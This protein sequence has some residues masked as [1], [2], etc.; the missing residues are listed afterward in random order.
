MRN[1]GRKALLGSVIVLFAVLA[2]LFIYVD[3][4][5]SSIVPVLMYHSIDPG[6]EGSSID[7]SPE[8]FAKQMEFL[9]RNHYNVVSPDKV[10]AYMKKEEKMPPKTA[11]IT[12]DDGYYN[13]YE[14]AYPVLKKYKLPA[15]IF[16]TTDRIGT[17]GYLG[18][19]ELREISASGLVTI[20]SHTKSHVWVPEISVNDERLH[21]ELAVSKD[22]LERALGKK[23]YYLCYPNGGFNDLAK[24]AAKEAGY[25]GAF[26]TNP[27]R[28]SDISDIYAIRRL[29]MSSSS[30]SP[31]ILW[32]KVSR[33]YAWFKERR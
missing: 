18:W 30:D 33:Y 2:G 14:Y 1:S 23:V 16:V 10:I 20:G 7:V 15:A 29:K 21:E 3:I 22:I 32:G 26:T 31:L 24:D 4:K 11:A 28:K 27:R 12:V 19:N 9:Y 6:K 13:F 8:I 5:S 17:P 25:K